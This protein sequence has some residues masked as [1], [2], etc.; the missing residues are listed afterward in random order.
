MAASV[1][2]NESDIS[3]HMSDS[4][5]A[6]FTTDSDVGVPKRKNYLLHSKTGNRPKLLKGASGSW[7]HVEDDRGSWKV[8]DGSGGAAVSCI[9]QGDERIFSAM[10]T[11]QDT[12]RT[13]APAAD[14][15][16]R[17]ALDLAQWLIES[18]GDQM[19]G[20]VFY[21][22][23]SDSVE[24]SLKL[25]CQYQR[26]AKVN[27]EPSR[28]LFIA[29]KS[30]YHGATLGSL[31]LSGH[32]ARK[33]SFDPILSNNTRFLSPCY[34]YRGLSE[35][36]TVEEYV[37]RLADELENEILRLGP[38]NVA[39]CILEPIVGAALGC[40]P[41]LPGYL[42]AMKSVC[43][44]HGVLFILDEIMCGMGRTGSLHAWK[45]ENVVPDIQVI[46]KGLAGGYADISGLLCS[47]EIFDAFGQGKTAFNHGHT[48]QNSPRN[49][50]A[51][52]A[53]QKVIREEGLLQNARE[54]GDLLSQKLK[55]R[56]LPHR[57]IGDIRGKGLFWGV[58][59]SQDKNYRH[60]DRRRSN[61]LATR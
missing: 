2:C 25:A 7:L 57:Y 52:L 6:S 27:P 35:H 38:K 44:R 17:P 60:T 15:V 11:D 14:F 51:A 37:R 45:A 32:Y 61:L 24:A 22:S 3:S 5:A 12:G 21:N 59:V 56:L 36:E 33:R 20:A 40:V 55:T 46:G 39:G 16:T 29:R 4:D 30:S 23:G 49:C 34:A 54:M 26:E 13:Y 31:D 48:F 42:K 9:G 58:R 41:A 19:G 47:S 18:T 28:C 43:R 50:A 1:L 8:F 10:K 53:V